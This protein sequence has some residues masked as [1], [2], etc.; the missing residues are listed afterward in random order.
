[1]VP[2]NAVRVS[3]KVFE[4][5]LKS[6]SAYCGYVK[7]TKPNSVRFELTSLESNL[8]HC[9]CLI[10][11]LDFDALKINPI[12]KIIYLAG[13]VCASRISDISLNFGCP[14]YS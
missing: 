9:N 1:M 14:Y 10:D 7:P 8:C 5:L 2:N 4:V 12:T 13:S 6:H 3:V 11:H